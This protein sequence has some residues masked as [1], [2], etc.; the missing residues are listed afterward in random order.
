M[1]LTFTLADKAK[2]KTGKFVIE[3]LQISDKLGNQDSQWEDDI[4]WDDIDLYLDGTKYEGDI[5]T[6]AGSNLGA[7]DIFEQCLNAYLR[8]DSEDY[9]SF[10]SEWSIFNKC[11]SLKEWKDDLLIKMPIFKYNQFVVYELDLATPKNR[12]YS[13]NDYFLLLDINGGILTDMECFYSEAMYE[14][15]CAILKGE[16]KCLYKSDNIDEMIKE[17]GGKE[18]FLKEFDN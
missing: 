8:N 7:D 5:Q 15:V 18:G 3:N 11:E 17:Y 12:Y 1:E 6:W 2:W 16:L 10:G 13:Y 14:D 4:T 9:E